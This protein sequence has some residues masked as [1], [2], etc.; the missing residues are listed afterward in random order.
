[1]YIYLDVIIKIRFKTQ[2]NNHAI[3]ETF[4]VLMIVW[5]ML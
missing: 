4:H 2:S 5:N 1:M 3:F